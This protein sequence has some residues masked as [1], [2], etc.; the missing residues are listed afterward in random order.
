MNTQLDKR[1]NAPPI[2][3]AITLATAAIL[4]VGTSSM[5]GAQN[6]SWT[7][8]FNMGDCNFSTT[9][10]NPYFILQPGYQLKF[11]GV[12]DGEPLD[13]T[14]IVSNETKVVGEGIV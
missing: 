8:T 3:T 9:G 14:V 7:S 10:T 5:V 13:V 11:A 2:V 4:I 12:E 1:S 6:E